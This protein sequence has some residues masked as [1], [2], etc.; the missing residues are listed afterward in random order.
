MAA[1]NTQEFTNERPLRQGAFEYR[2][3]R[4]RVYLNGKIVYG[5]GAFSSDCVIRDLSYGGAKI[6]VRRT[7][8]MPSSLYLI[9]V[10]NQV[11]HEA[12][13][14]WMN[15]PARGLQF[16]NTYHLN[17]NIPEDVQFLKPLWE[18]LCTRGMSPSYD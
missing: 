14:T 16:I 12:K 13:V 4:R 10:K 8:M 5:Q 2:E 1:L 6:V 9:A 17:D 15:V 7:Q 18:S 11:A 3:P